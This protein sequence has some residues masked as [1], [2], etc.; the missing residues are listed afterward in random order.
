MAIERYANTVCTGVVPPSSLAGRP[1]GPRPHEPTSAR[2]H[3]H[4]SV[5]RAGA[6]DAPLRAESALAGLILLCGS[7]NVGSDD[8]TIATP[9][10]GE[11][12]LAARALQVSRAAT[13]APVEVLPGSAK[14][15]QPES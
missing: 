4:S 2:K 14:R 15:Q 9:D 10:S 5:C 1:H 6:G 12:P 13:S 8:S 7:Q 11:R 3:T